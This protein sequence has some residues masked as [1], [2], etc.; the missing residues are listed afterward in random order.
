MIKSIKGCLNSGMNV[1]ANF[2]FG[3]PGDTYKM[4]WQTCVFMWKLAIAR[5]HDISI[6]PFCPYPGSDLFRV[7]QK[8][9]KIPKKLDDN[10]YKELPLADM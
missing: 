8:E 7:L 1:K 2:I 4:H 10:Y 6:S 3:F 5:L 9:G